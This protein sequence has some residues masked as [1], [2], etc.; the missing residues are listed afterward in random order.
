VGSGRLRVR[1]R[2]SRSCAKLFATYDGSMGKSNGMAMGIETGPMGKLKEKLSQP[3][4]GSPAA[5]P[6]GRPLFTPAARP[7]PLAAGRHDQRRTLAQFAVRAA[8]AA[9][10]F[11]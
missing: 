1:T 3:I 2:R 5:R 7:V 11:P 4:S 9:I 10:D 8:R 6:G